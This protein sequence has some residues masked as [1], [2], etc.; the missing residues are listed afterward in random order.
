[1]AAAQATLFFLRAHLDSMLDPAAMRLLD[2]PRFM[3]L[4]ERYLNVTTVL[5]LAGFVHLWGMLAGLK[6]NAAPPPPPA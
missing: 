1:M 4:H 5:C 2:R 3:P 6:P